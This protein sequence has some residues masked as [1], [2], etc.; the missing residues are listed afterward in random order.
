MFFLDFQ[1]KQHFPSKHK[2]NIIVSLLRSTYSPLFSCE[3]ITLLLFFI[4]F[5]Y[6]I[7]RIDCR[8]LSFLYYLDLVPPNSSSSGGW[9]LRRHNQP[10]TSRAPT[11]SFPAYTTISHQ[12]VVETNW[13]KFTYCCGPEKWALPLLSSTLFLLLF[14]PFCSV[15]II[16]CHSTSPWNDALVFVTVLAAELPISPISTFLA[17]EK[18]YR[19]TRGTRTGRTACPNALAWEMMLRLLLPILYGLLTEDFKNTASGCRITQAGPALQ[20]S[21]KLCWPHCVFGWDIPVHLLPKTDTIPLSA[22]AQGGMSYL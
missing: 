13:D 1:K 17:A 21:P 18:S 6:L 15:R 22:M 16:L 8:F 3:I 2:A 11:I 10:Q 5:A 4:H 9:L 12:P 19:S 7:G 20:S 14:S